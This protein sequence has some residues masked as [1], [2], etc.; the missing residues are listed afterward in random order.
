MLVFFDWFEMM[1][2]V[3]FFDWRIFGGVVVVVIFL[4]YYFCG[5]GFVFSVYFGF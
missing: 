5:L 1:M 4:V 2:K 3:F